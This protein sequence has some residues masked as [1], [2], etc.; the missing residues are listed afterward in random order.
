MLLAM[1]LAH[2]RRKQGRGPS[3]RDDNRPLE[4]GYGVA[5]AAVAGFVV[6][7]SIHT[8]NE[9]APRNVHAA[10][11]VRVTGFRW[12]WRFDYPGH[13]PGHH[14]SVTGQCR[15]G[16]MPTMVVP[17]G[18]PVTIETTGRDVI[19][20]WWVPELRYKMDSFPDHTNRFTLTVTSAGRFRGRC[21]EYCGNYHWSM[22]FWLKAVPLPR[23]KQWLAAAAGASA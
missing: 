13:Y 6:W 7:L 16:D 10:T 3:G 22:D 14:V 19:H 4:I 11:T 1:W 18:V 5:V 17:V 9:V 21:A 12:C 2:R 8:N 23:Y 20:S 15:V